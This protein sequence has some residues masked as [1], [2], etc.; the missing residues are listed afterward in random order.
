MTEVWIAGA[1]AVALAA[2][3]FAVSI[4]LSTRE[5]SRAEMAS[6]VAT[7]GVLHALMPTLGL[8]VGASLMGAVSWLSTWGAPTVLFAIALNM[9]RE[10]FADDDDAAHDDAAHDALPW[11]A[12]LGLG[13]AT[14]VDAFGVGFSLPSMVKAQGAAIALIAGVAAGG[15]AIGSLFG[16]ALSSKLGRWV[17]VVGA[18]LL[19]V[20]AARMVW[21]AA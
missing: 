9:V 10:A 13:L 3:S 2:D 11:I 6:W 18:L 15:A 19:V 8:W 4:A 17:E 14:S 20:V 1:T 5:R 7:V 12:L 16:R 21:Q